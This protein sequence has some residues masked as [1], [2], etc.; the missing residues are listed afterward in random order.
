MSKVDIKELMKADFW[1]MISLVGWKVKNES[2]ASVVAQ[3][4][5]TYPPYKSNHFKDIAI[6]LVQELQ[7][8][9]LENITTKVNRSE[10]YVAGFEVVAQGRAIYQK[11]QK[12]PELLNQLMESLDFGNSDGLFINAIPAEDEYYQIQ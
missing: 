5:K 8:E 3:I 10:L 11:Y 6:D 7:Q 1:K 9:Y 2:A 4:V 12:D